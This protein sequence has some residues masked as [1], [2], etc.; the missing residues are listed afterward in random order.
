M[1]KIFISALLLSVLMPVSARKKVE[2]QPSMT[3]QRMENSVVIS[4]AD[5]VYV[6]PRTVLRVTVNVEL[7][8]FTRG[9]YSDYAEKYLGISD[10]K[11]KSTDQYSIRSIEVFSM[12]EADPNEM[13]IV[14]SVQGT[15]SGFLKLQQAG[16]TMVAPMPVNTTAIVVPMPERDWNMPI[17]T[18]L[19]YEAGVY[20]S[21]STK[22][23]AST[24]NDSSKAE[25]QPLPVS[26]PPVKNKET[27]AMEAAKLLTQLRRRRMELVSGEIVEAFANGDALKTAI[28]EIK[29]IEQQ[30]LELFTGKTEYSETTYYYD[31]IPQKGK[32]HYPLFSF[33]ADNGMDAEQQPNIMLHLQC[34]DVFTSDNNN[35]SAYKYRI[36]CMSN[37]RITDGDIELF[38]GRYAVFQ[39][40]RMINMFPA[41]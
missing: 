20:K 38:R 14:H 36:P 22:A 23:H 29:N 16:L 6:L 17:F 21:S 5:F 19:G 28:A 9:I 27:R 4:D 12:Q 24:T 11:K 34:P 41:P 33:S 35:T 7:S 32:E 37:L 13:Y 3:V 18:D 31:I 10:V 25:R 2:E 40:G 15:P 8:Q 1:K 26:V 39:Y 30:Y